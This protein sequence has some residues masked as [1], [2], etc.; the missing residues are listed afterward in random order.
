VPEARRTNA[1]APSVS[2]M[3]ASSTVVVASVERAEEGV[4][5]MPAEGV[6]QPGMVM[7]S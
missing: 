2:S 7:T 5:E 4:Q 6:V 3:S 1:G